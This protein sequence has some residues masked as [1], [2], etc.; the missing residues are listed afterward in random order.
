MLALWIYDYTNSRLTHFD[1]IKYSSISE[2]YRS[3]F[4]LK[5]YIIR[6]QFIIISDKIKHKSIILTRIFYMCILYMYT[7]VTRNLAYYVWYAVWLFIIY[8]MHNITLSRGIKNTL[9]HRTLVLLLNVLIRPKQAKH[10]PT[11]WAFN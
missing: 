11:Q 6:R 1:W 7:C 8:L 9:W 3:T 4:V 10:K 5:I 2:W